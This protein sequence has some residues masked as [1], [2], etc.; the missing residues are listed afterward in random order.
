MRPPP[1]PPCQGGGRIETPPL[2]KGEAGRG[3]YN[4]KS[5]MDLRIVNTCNSNCLYCLEQSLRAKE[6]HIPKQ[7]IFDEIEK[8]R[9]DKI[10]TFYG[11]N[12]LLHPNL[13]DI[14]RFSKEKGFESIGLLTNTLWLDDSLLWELKDSGLTSIGFYFHSF[15]K[16]RHSRVVYSGISL[17]QL[18]KNIE[19]IQKSRLFYKAIIHLNNQNIGT[20]FRDLVVL[21]KKFGITNIECINYFPFDRPYNEHRELLEYDVQKKRQ[22]IDTIFKAIKTLKIEANFVK[23]PREFFWEYDEFYNFERWIFEQIGDEDRE[24]LWEGKVPFCFEEKRC[25]SCFIKDNCEY[26]G[27]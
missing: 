22:I 17:A 25:G 23:F 3:L 1:T 4:K 2:T 19:N 21:N 24:R 10:I 14:I 18:L 8:N 7:E 5:L 6:K 27:L 15:N 13:K 12:P 9:D 20:L 16:E 26:Y 11:G